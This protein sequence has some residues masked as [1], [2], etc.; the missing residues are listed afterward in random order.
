MYA[1]PSFFFPPPLT[2]PPVGQQ[3]RTSL[4]KDYQYH[5]IRYDDLKLALKKPLITDPT[6]ENPRPKRQWSEKDEK[7]FIE[8]LEGELDR[9]FSFQRT[10]YKEIVNRIDNSEEEVKDVLKRLESYDET[11]NKDNL[12]EDFELLEQDLSDIIAD[13]HDLAKY[14]Q[15]NYTGFQKIVKKHDVCVEELGV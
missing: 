1:T 5:Y 15:L 10:K 13:V 2:S 6:P 14:T 9:V 3:L 7:S 4:I 11:E 12:A 8:Q